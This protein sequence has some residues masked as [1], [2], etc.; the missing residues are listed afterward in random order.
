MVQKIKDALSKWGMVPVSFT[1][2]MSGRIKLT[3]GHT[4]SYPKFIDTL[5]ERATSDSDLDS[6]VYV[7]LTMGMKRD[8]LIKYLCEAYPPKKLEIDADVLGGMELEDIDKCTLCYDIEDKNSSFSS[9]CFIVSLT[10]DIVPIRTEVFCKLRGI[11]AITSAIP[12]R[13]VY[14]PFREERMLKVRDP[15]SKL[16]I[17]EINTYEPPLWKAASPKSKVV[18]PPLFDKFL[19]AVFDTATYGRDERD[20]FEFWLYKALT[21]RA[22]TV[23]ILNGAA[24]IGKGVLKSS[25]IPLFGRENSKDG[26]ISSLEGS[27]NGVFANSTYV[28]FDE[29]A[30]SGR[31]REIFKEVLNS[32]V[33]IENKFENS[34]GR[35]RIYCSLIVSNNNERFNDLEYSDR[36]FSPLSLSKKRLETFLDSKEFEE[37]KSYYEG[38]HPESALF[39][40]AIGNYLQRVGPTLQNKYPMGE[41]EYL[42]PSFF[43]ICYA[44]LSDFNKKI[45]YSFFGKSQMPDGE[46]LVCP[47]RDLILEQYSKVNYVLMSTV[48][49][50]VN[51]ASRGSKNKPD[52]SSVKRFMTEYRDI[53]GKN[54]FIIEE[55]DSFTQDFVVKVPDSGYISSTHFHMYLDEYKRENGYLPKLERAEDLL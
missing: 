38:T 8:E 39:Y 34:T 50:V 26:K 30:I 10:G 35:T 47:T 23:L 29:K 55:I 4:K 51:S 40:G 7:I 16:L 1:R 19:N 21:S 17:L 46:S 43:R 54:P 25:I 41:G 37:L 44:G 11:E 6:D 42:G 52:I 31:A 14:N 5:V 22:P 18:L 45:I 27:F 13:K 49:K 32:T 36:K 53:Q 28:H 2:D 3:S 24:G 15:I 48:L 33:S 9:A 20:Y 12:S